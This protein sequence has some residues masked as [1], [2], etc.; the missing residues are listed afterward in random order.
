MEDASDDE[1]GLFFVDG[2]DLLHVVAGFVFA[3]DDH[4]HVVGQVVVLVEELP[5]EP[6]QLEVVEGVR[7]EDHVAV[8]LFVV[9]F[10]VAVAHFEQVADFARL[11]REED[12]RRDEEQ[13]DANPGEGAGWHDVAVAYCRDGDDD[14]LEGNVKGEG[15]VGSHVHS[16]RVWELLI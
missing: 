6:E 13:A 3:D 12:H 4:L 11:H 16:K 14:E 7:G 10:L 8:G 9:G 1:E 5:Q 2:D 15:V